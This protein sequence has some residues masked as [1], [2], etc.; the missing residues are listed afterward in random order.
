MLWIISV[1]QMLCVTNK[2][3]NYFTYFQQY[4]YSK[5]FWYFYFGIHEYSF[6]QEFSR[7]HIY[8]YDIYKWEIYICDIYIYLYLYAFDCWEGKNF[9]DN[10]EILF[11]SQ[12]KVSTLRLLKYYAG[13]QK[14]LCLKMFVKN[15]ITG[16]WNLSILFLQLPGNLQLSQTKKFLKLCHAMAISFLLSVCP[17]MHLYILQYLKCIYLTIKENPDFVIMLTFLG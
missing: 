5:Q 1:T 12:K 7:K 3:S 15:E 10:K 6:F 16:I 13:T 8:I 14:W 2:Y 9:I 4:I 11:R 17:S